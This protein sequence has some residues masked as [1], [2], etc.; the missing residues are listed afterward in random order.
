MMVVSTTLPVQSAPRVRWTGHVAGSPSYRRLVSALVAGGLAN[1]SL[2]YFVQPLLPMLADHYGVSAA[3]SAHA[4]SITTLTVMAG[5]MAAGPL[6]DRVGR[7]NVMRWSLLASGG[8]GLLSAFAP[9]WPTLLATRALLGFTLAGLPVAALAYLREEVHPGSHGRA[10]AAYIAGTAVGGAVARLLPG[11][12]A[13]LGGWQL[14]AAV[15]SLIT[16]AAGVALCLMLPRSQGFA[17][18]PVSL[19]HVLLGTLSAPRDRVIALLCVAGFASMGTFVAVYNAI[20]FRL[21]APPLLLGAAAALVYLVHPF[22]IAAPLSAKLLSDRI[23]RGPAAAVGAGMMAIGVVALSLPSLAAIVIGL[24]LTTIAF[25]GLHSLLSGWVVD[26]AK[27]RGIGTAQASSAYLF[28]YY[29]GSTLA[30]ALATRQWQSGG[31]AGV[32]WLG[33]ALTAT[34]LLVVVAATRTERGRQLSLTRS[35]EGTVPA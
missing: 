31:W 28:A 23:G 10:N 25:L 3:E 30:G 29:L 2:M 32:E 11:P 4:L 20:G 13:A 8:F 7:V 22:G 27:R 18:R 26:R 24:G 19:R 6:A 17:P 35:T 1:F 14:A 21:A 12:L 34:A 33:L 16:V 15:V 5:L 9:D